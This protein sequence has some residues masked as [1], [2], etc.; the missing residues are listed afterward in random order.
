MAIRSLIGPG[1]MT[2]AD[3]CFQK[4]MLLLLVLFQTPGI[5]VRK[6]VQMNLIAHLAKALFTGMTR[7]QMMDP[8]LALHHH[9]RECKSDAHQEPRRDLGH[10]EGHDLLK[11]HMDVRHPVPL[12]LLHLPRALATCGNIILHK[13]PLHMVMLFSPLLA[14]PSS[15]PPLPSQR[16]FVSKGV[17]CT[18]QIPSV[19]SLCNTQPKTHFL[20]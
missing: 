11:I 12:F 20:G 6:K 19:L 17:F 8:L 1:Q 9:P 3:L 13:T 2:P 4:E 16:L 15:C 10:R 18:K 5:V 14:G 7:Q